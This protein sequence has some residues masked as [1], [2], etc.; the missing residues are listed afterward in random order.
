VESWG[1]ESDG[2]ME[3]RLRVADNAVQPLL[4]MFPLGLFA[5][6]NIF[7][8]AT[9]A[10]APRLLGTAAYWT[11]LAGLVGGAAA[12]AL[13]A[14]DVLSAQSVRATRLGTVGILLDLGV[15]IIFS[16]IALTRL[17]TDYRGTDPG[18]LLVEGLA[19]TV[20]V[21]STWFGGRLGP[22]PA[23]RWRA[24]PQPARHRASGD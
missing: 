17:R 19:L 5:M 6:A 10:G 15:L 1:E 12:T 22:Q 23:A 9:M 20:A 13:G 8:V 7:D 16:V 21:V 18:L 24:A 2:R 3:S 11:I 14:L 4:L